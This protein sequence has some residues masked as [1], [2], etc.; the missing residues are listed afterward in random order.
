MNNF[1]WLSTYDIIQERLKE[2]YQLKDISEQEYYRAKLSAF[3]RWETEQALLTKEICYLKDWKEFLDIK[4]IEYDNTWT[5][6][7]VK[8]N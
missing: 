3:T 2:L 8:T 7:N 4:N 1:E 6:D 5:W